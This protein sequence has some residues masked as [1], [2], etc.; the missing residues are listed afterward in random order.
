MSNP[1]NEF[2][3]AVGALAETMGLFWRELRKQGFS[4]E[5]ALELTKVFLVQTYDPL[6]QN[7]PNS[8][9]DN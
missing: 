3:T 1:L 7:N 6:N 5:E 9:E 4:P 2:V 8:E